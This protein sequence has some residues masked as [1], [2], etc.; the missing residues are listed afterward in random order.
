MVNVRELEIFGNIGN[1]G[2]TFL[3]CFDAI[4]SKIEVAERLIFNDLP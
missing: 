3:I 1:I 2:T 4:V